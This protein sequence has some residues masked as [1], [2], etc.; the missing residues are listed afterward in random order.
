MSAKVQEREGEKECV[1]A[2]VFVC[3]F[4]CACVTWERKA[5]LKGWGEGGDGKWECEVF[6]IY[7]P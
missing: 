2:C 6:E 1:H 3:A 4:V 7:L 5:E